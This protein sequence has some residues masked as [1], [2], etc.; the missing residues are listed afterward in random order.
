MQFTSGLPQVSVIEPLMFLA[1][2]DDITMGTFTTNCVIY[3]LSLENDN[4]LLP[5]EFVVEEKHNLVH[6]QPN[7][8]QM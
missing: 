8:E 1:L 3:K 7:L 4:K 5:F 6:L 2:M